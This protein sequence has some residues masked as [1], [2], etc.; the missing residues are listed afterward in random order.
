MRYLPLLAAIL[1]IA[2]VPA[3]GAPSY[4]GGFTGGIYTPDGLIE[5]TR[6][7]DVSYHDTLKLFGGTD[8][9]ATGVLIGAA[10]NLEL[11]VAFLSNNDSNVTI[12][13]KY[14]IISETSTVPAVLIGGFDIAGSANFLNANPGFYIVLSKNITTFASEATNTQL[15]ALRATVG[16]GSGIFNGFF[17]GLDYI[18]DPRLSI[19]AEFNGGNIGGETNFI[20]AGVR[21]SASPDLRLDVA[22]AGFKQ[23]AFGA[24]YRVAIP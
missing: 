3:L 20:N 19:I 2:A 21:W 17:A 5:P 22:Y 7:V 12:S 16:A 23:L 6:S 4:L 15:H 10:P 18:Y 24:S 8:V 1:L 9:K 13:G 11:G 14:R